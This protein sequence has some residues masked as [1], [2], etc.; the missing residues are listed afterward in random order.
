MKTACHVRRETPSLAK[1]ERVN[2]LQTGLPENRHT[3][4]D[5]SAPPFVSRI[6]ESSRY[7]KAGIVGL[8]FAILGN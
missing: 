6:P 8:T 4:R 3:R 7:R 1:N 5:Q 2:L